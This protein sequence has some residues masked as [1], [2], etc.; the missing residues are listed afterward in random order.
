M[1]H[2]PHSALC[3]RTS[4]SYCKYLSAFASSLEFL[5]LKTTKFDSHQIERFYSIQI[6]THKYTFPKIRRINTK[7]QKLRRNF[8]DL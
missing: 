1:Q 6:D 7:I 2:L 3:T 8:F 4:T 5:D